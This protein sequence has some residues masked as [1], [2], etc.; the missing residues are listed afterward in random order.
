MRFAAVPALVDEL[1]GE[2]DV[3]PAFRPLPPAEAAS[4]HI[5]V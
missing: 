1:H 3:P 2:A 5:S 4:P